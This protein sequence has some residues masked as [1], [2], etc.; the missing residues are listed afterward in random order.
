MKLIEVA[1]VDRSSTSLRWVNPVDH[2]G[3]VVYQDEVK[4]EFYF[5]AVKFRYDPKDVMEWRVIALHRSA[6][7]ELT[8][9]HKQ[10]SEILLSRRDHIDFVLLSDALVFEKMW[11]RF[12]ELLNEPVPTGTDTNITTRR[13]TL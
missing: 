12:Q 8:N 13:V 4:P 5:A 7:A 6:S 10:A 3:L 1:S 11:P 2:K 9:R